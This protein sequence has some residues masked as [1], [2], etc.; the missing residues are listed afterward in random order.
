MQVDFSSLPGFL[1]ERMSAAMKNYKQYGKCEYI[2]N[3]VIGV[4]LVH[5]KK[6]KRWLYLTT[7]RGYGSDAHSGMHVY[8][9][10]KDVRIRVSAC[11]I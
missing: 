6:Q 2:A 5:V 7:F 3:N 4:K 11:L 8:V 10:V 1:E 9:L